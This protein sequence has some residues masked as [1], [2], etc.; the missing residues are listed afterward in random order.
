MLHGS[1]WSFC[2]RLGS[3]F[4]RT[5]SK[6]SSFFNKIH[7]YCSDIVTG[8][9][10][11]GLLCPNHHYILGID[12]NQTSHCKNWLFLS[13]SQ[14]HL[15]SFHTKYIS[16][17]ETKY[18]ICLD[19][20]I[21]ARTEYLHTSVMFTQSKLSCLFQDGWKMKTHSLGLSV[22]SLVNKILELFQP[23]CEYNVENKSECRY[24]NRVINTTVNRQ[25]C[26][27]F[28]FFF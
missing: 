13:F 22:N 2:F 18:F 16:F 26:L 15:S 6:A 5:T 23:P 24:S 12:S 8:E 20:I 27:R 7:F 19:L 10:F 11:P 14:L 9:L 17:N 25:G 21:G 1:F 3:V 4:L 28:I